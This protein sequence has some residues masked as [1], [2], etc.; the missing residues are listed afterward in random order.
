[1]SCGTGARARKFEL[2][3]RLK[4]LIHTVSSIPS[5]TPALTPA[6]PSLCMAASGTRSPTTYTSATY[7]VFRNETSSLR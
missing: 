6:T 1:M 4:N 3:S 5:S 2:R 7:L